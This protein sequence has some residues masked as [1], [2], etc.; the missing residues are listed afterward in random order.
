MESTA[1]KMVNQQLGLHLLC[2]LVN[3]YTKHANVY[4]YMEHGGQ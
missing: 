2:N 3:V 4:I 1:S